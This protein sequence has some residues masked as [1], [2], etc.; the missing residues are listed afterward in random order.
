MQR[1]TNS[2]KRRFARHR[3][4]WAGEE[5]ERAE[6]H[7]VFRPR[8]PRKLLRLFQNIGTPEHLP[9]VPDDFQREALELIQKS[10]VLVSAPTGSGKTW[11]AVQAMR[12][13]LAEGK[14][15]WY[16]SPLK[17]LSNS[18][19]H[20]FTVEFG[21]D[22]V[23]VLT[24]D[25]KEN[26]D[27]PIIVGT[28]E[29]L[30]NQLYDAMAQG[31]DFAS[32]LVVLDEAHYL[33]DRE[34][35]VVWEEVMIYLPARVRLLMLS[36]T[37][38]NDHEIAA[39]L[40]SIRRHPC[41]VVH[42]DRRPVPLYPLYLLP[43]GELVLLTEG[44]KINPRIDHYLKHQKT[45]KTDR[46]RTQVSYAD[47]LSVLAR[48]NLLPA[49]F[50]L[51]SRAECNNALLACRHHCIDPMRSR[52]LRHRIDEL[53]AE[54]PFLANHPQLPAVVYHGLGAHHGGQLPHWKL[55]IEKLMNEGYL[56]AIFST[57]TVAAGVNFPART[58]VLVQSDRFDGRSFVSLSATDLH[59]ATGRA[60]RRGK[61]KIGFAVIVHGPFQDPHLIKELFS[62]EPEPI[63]SQININFSMA[64][65]LLLSHRPDEIEQLL[66]DSFATFQHMDA[67]RELE[68]KL[69][70]IRDKIACKMDGSK[71][72]T[73]VQVLERVRQ[74]RFLLRQLG[75]RHAKAAPPDIS[76]VNLPFA[77]QGA[78][79]AEPTPDNC[80][81]IRSLLQALPCDECP[82]FG[83]CHQGKH[84]HFIKLLEKARDVQQTMEHARNALWHDFQRHLDFL[85]LTGFA[86][87]HGKLTPDG[88][89]ASMLR[90]DH[91]L[92][93]A[94]LIRKGFFEDISEEI[95][96]GI[97]AIFVNDKF[98]DID[99]NPDMTWEKRPLL[100]QYYRM[101]DVIAE[102]LQLKEAHGFATPQIQFW[103]AVALYVW[104][105]GTVWEDVLRLT[106]IDEGDL[107]MLVFRTADNLR[108]IASLSETHPTIAAKARRIIDTLLRE[109]VVI[110]T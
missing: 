33:G 78:Q 39:W 64:L 6:Q 95:M 100:T 8:A 46:M 36:A 97:I 74:R 2:L 108:Q 96:A 26:T 82:T 43:D 9:F 4:R 45:L 62:N 65:N 28:T 15:A 83:L 51:K 103:P 101:K 52:A 93:I 13:I 102:L 104:A 79:T 58:V 89:W 86:D 24:G 77:G 10:D 61:D 41:A 107:A 1:R 17:A 63:E 72:E 60:G 54:Y 50:F 38:R 59:Q 57:S 37:I 31:S 105:G 25:R 19:Y 67:V 99:I 110:P 106:S 48:F 68:R 70:A 55:V 69:Q 12:R 81:H 11:I 56:D 35:G 88:I 76:P 109:P 7:G 98:R 92:I 90:L 23:G 3:R 85:T 94:E 32:D 87:E 84:N 30:R 66:K 27:A 14:R 75:R 34:R 91:P 21:E 20:E 49:I 73:F 53:L 44:G 80:A 71:C 42:S 18:K 22:R 29:I 47:I 16:A 40:T 5:N